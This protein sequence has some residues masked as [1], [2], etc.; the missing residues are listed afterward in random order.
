MRDYVKFWRGYLS[1]G[2]HQYFTDQA[3]AASY[4]S[5][6]FVEGLV[7]GGVQPCWINLDKNRVVQLINLA[8]A[9]NVQQYISF[10]KGPG[11]FLGEAS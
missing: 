6:R 8:A 3:G 1:T 10:S 9:S 2:E 11:R 4:V 5:G 7:S